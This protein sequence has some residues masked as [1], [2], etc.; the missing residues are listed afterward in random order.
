MNRNLFG[1][2]CLKI[3]SADGRFSKV[4]LLH[5]PPRR[6]GG[7]R[8]GL[9]RCL[10]SLAPCSAG[11][12]VGT[13]LLLSNS[14]SVPAEEPVGT[15]TVSTRL[16]AAGIGLSWGDGVLTYQGQEIPF[17]F[18]ANGLFRNVDENITAAELSGQVFNLNNP[19]DFAGNYQKVEEKDSDNAAGSSATMKNE[20]GVVVNLVSIVAGRKFNLSREGLK[21]EFKAQKPSSEGNSR[22]RKMLAANASVERF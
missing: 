13:V 19:A 18:Q 22:R 2:L 14:V 17:T 11:F 8:W 6:G 3:F 5:P 10:F 4:P 15:I 12:I 9:C 16:V 20:K 21:V 1:L 7:K